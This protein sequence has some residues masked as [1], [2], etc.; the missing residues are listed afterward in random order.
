MLGAGLVVAV[1][2]GGQQQLVPVVQQPLELEPGVAAAVVGVTNAGP[3]VVWSHSASVAAVDFAGI[4]VS[5]GLVVQLL[6]TQRLLVGSA[7]GVAYGF[8]VA[9]VP[10][11]AAAV[12]VVVR[13]PFG[14]GLV[15]IFVGAAAQ[16]FHSTE[17]GRATQPIVVVVDRSA[18]RRVP[19]TGFEIRMKGFG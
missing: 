6:L 4:V 2:V 7:W 11:F 18:W 17:P 15:W 5:V 3:P 8:V 14:C 10:G 1:V 9:V 16:L 12:V 19:P 13:V